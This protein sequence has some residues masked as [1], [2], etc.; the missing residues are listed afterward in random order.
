MEITTPIVEVLM[1]E[2]PM[3]ETP[4]VATPVEETPMEENKAEYIPST[5]VAAVVEEAKE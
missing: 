4:M 5:E 1:K 3:E 2:T